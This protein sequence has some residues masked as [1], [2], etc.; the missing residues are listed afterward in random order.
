MVARRR[1]DDAQRGVDLHALAQ[2]LAA[3]GHTLPVL[4]RFNHILHDRVDVLC[5][6]FAQ[7]IAEQGYGGRY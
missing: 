7:A 2:A 4:V 1:A 6:A 3:Q 5:G